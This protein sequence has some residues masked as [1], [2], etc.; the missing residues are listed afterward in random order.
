MK[1]VLLAS[2][3]VLAGMFISGASVET[4]SA[5]GAIHYVAAGKS[6][7]YKLASQSTKIDKG[8]TSPEN[9][10]AV[11][12]Y[13]AGVQNNQKYVAKLKNNTQNLTVNL[14][15]INQTKSVG[16]KGKTP[17]NAKVLYQLKADGLGTA[18]YTI[19]NNKFYVVNKHKQFNKKGVSFGK[20]VSLANK[21]NAGDVLTKLAGTVNVQDQ[22]GA[23]GNSAATNSNSNNATN[24]SNNANVNN[25]ASQPAN[26]QG[27][28]A[29]SSSE[30]PQQKALDAMNADPN[31]DPD[32]KRRMNL[33]PDDPDYI[34]ATH[35]PDSWR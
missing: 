26:N 31:V 10:A 30:S 9:T 8:N 13:Y 14:L 18:Y 21:N 2:T 33:P 27:T 5:D 29:N 32:L 19:A 20:M 24:G 16:I 34:P 4:V 1:K 7:N 6:M 25:G 15:D 17:K 11:V 22:R 23:N 12:F 35:D 28:N 3:L